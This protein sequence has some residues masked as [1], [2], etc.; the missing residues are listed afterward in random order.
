[1]NIRI[2]LVTVNSTAF[3]GVLHLPTSVG[4]WDVELNTPLGAQQVV[5]TIDADGTGSMGGL[6]GEQEIEGITFD[7]N[8][9]NFSTSI[10]AQGKAL[11][12]ILVVQLRGVL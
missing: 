12:W 4:I 3:I 11:L 8:A 5:L 10:D 7:G 9:L 2:F 6:Q 1:M